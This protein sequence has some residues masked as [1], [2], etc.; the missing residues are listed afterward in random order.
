MRSLTPH[1]TN[2]DSSDYVQKPESSS[3]LSHNPTQP[4]SAI[5]PSTRND[6]SHELAA[7]I[8]RHAF[9]PGTAHPTTPPKSAE[10]ASDKTIP[11]PNCSA[12]AHQYTYNETSAFHPPSSASR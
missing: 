3:V 12:P 2:P 10:T 7:A 9:P 4:A 5:L 8:D 6:P 1:Q 11:Y